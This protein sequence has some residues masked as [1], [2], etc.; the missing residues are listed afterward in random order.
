MDL[1]TL[2]RRFTEDHVRMAQFFML[3]RQVGVIL[4]SIVIARTLPVAQVGILEML[5]LCGYLMTFFWSDALLKGYLAN[6]DGALEKHHNSSFLWFFILAAFFSMGVLVLGQHFIIPLLVGRSDLSGLHLFAAYQALII[7]LWIAPFIGILKRNNGWLISIY[8]LIGPPLA[9]WMGYLLLPELKGILSGLVGYSFLG[10]TGVMLQTRF[11]REMNLRK[12]LRTLWPVTWPLAMYAVST[13]LARSFDLWL[14]AREFSDA[15]FA[16]FRYGARE[17]PVVVALAAGLS[18]VM[19]PMLKTEGAVGELKRRSTKLMHYAYPMVAIVMLFSPLLFSW[20]F[21][22]DYKASAIIF[23]VYLL[24]ALT[25]LIFPQSVLI[26]REETKVLW[27]VSVMELIIN[28][29][30]SLFLLQ[31]FGLVGIALG[32]LVAFVFEKLILLLL[33]YRRY[34]I[35]PQQLLNPYVWILYVGILLICFI[36]SKWMFGI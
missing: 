3:C 23:N 21:G 25:Q 26:A 6:P 36:A 2:Y 30:A 16:F 9:C 12:M 19:I 15:T 10:L 22:A 34:G 32:T 27:Y 35:R 7:P 8:V 33:V 18:T 14:V 31:F 17:F 1:T 4:S 11:V 29:L 13:G 20:F 5:M 28:V 24:L